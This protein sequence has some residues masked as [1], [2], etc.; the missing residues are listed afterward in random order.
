VA[1]LRRGRNKELHPIDEAEAYERCHGGRGDDVRIVKVE[2]RRPRFDLGFSGE[3]LR[4]AFESRL[5][6]RAPEDE[7]EPGPDEIEEPQVPLDL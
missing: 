5:D 1:L 3:S 7:V 2:P 6:K 4:E